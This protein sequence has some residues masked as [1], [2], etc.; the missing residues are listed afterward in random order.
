MT[1]MISPK[2]RRSEIRQLPDIGRDPPPQ[3]A[4]FYLSDEMSQIVTSLMSGRSFWSR[5]ADRPSAALT[6]M[7]PWSDRASV[8]IVASLHWRFDSPPRRV[9]EARHCIG[10]EGKAAGCVPLAALLYLSRACDAVLAFWPAAEL[11]P[12]SEPKR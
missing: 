5:V 2:H 8:K 11:P 4:P 10:D 6:G 9:G 12:S 3:A 1:S 7:L